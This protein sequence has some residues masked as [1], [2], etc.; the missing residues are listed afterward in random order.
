VS[1]S[2][3]ARFPTS[4]FWLIYF[5]LI[6]FRLAIHNHGSGRFTPG[7]FRC[8]CSSSFTTWDLGHLEVRTWYVVVGCQP[9]A[10]LLTIS[11]GR[12][13]QRHRPDDSVSPAHDVFNT[14]GGPYIIG[15]RRGVI[16]EDTSYT[17]LR[18]AG[19]I[20]LTAAHPDDSWAC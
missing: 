13:R 1:S 16:F 20:Q 6:Y 19:I 5:W 18:P 7:T 14:S 12:T 2:K 3:A 9:S 15:H 11:S 17:L 4:Y 10:T 8:H